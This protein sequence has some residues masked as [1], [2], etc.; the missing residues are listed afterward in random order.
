MTTCWFVENFKLWIDFIGTILGALI[1]GI[2]ALL[3]VKIQLKKQ[4]KQELIR[5]NKDKE[6]REIQLLWQIYFDIKKDCENSRLWNKYEELLKIQEDVS[7]KVWNYSSNE[8][9]RETLLYI[10]K[11]IRDLFILLDEKESGIIDNKYNELDLLWARAAQLQV[12][13][14]KILDALDPSKEID[15]KIFN[16]HEEAFALFQKHTN[17]LKLNKGKQ[18]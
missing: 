4:G 9:I 2:I 1:G 12:F 3:I 16:Y 11:D 18:F 5:E 8:Y 7:S 10:M 6:E 13:M 15:L 14:I 17:Y